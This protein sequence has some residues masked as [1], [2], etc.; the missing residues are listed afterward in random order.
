MYGIYIV[1]AGVKF[2]TTK[3]AYG[4]KIRYK[5]Q[6]VTAV[7]LL[8]FIAFHVGTLH[9]WGLVGL[10]YNIER[11]HPLPDPLPHNDKGQVDFTKFDFIQRFSWWCTDYGGRFQ[12][13]GQAYQTTVQGVRALIDYSDP[14]TDPYN[15]KTHPANVF[16]M[17]FYLLGIWSATFHL[18]NG[19]WTS[20]IAWGLTVTEQTQRRWGHVCLGIGIVVLF[21]GTTAWYAFT[22]SPK[23]L[24]RPES[25]EF[26]LCRTD[27]HLA[28][29]P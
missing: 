15:D 25:L 5:L 2:D 27:T 28:T 26:R 29:A 7:I 20:A 4:G 17:G 16:V 9:K 18:A 10:H 1:K 13:D 11:V 3:Y 22:V 12:A 21:F 6:R 23:A 14:D 8:A 19:L 24:R